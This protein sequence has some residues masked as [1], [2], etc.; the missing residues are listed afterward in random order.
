MLLALDIGNSQT[1]YGIFDQG[2]LL[3]HWRAET[4]IS[5]TPDEHAA[6]LFPLLQHAGLSLAKWEGIALCSVV[7]PVEDS[8]TLFC[9]EYLKKEP[10]K[11]NHQSVLNFRLNVETPSEVGADRLANVAYAVKHL[12]L[13]AIVVDLGTATTFDVIT[14]DRVYQG[15]VILPGI[16]MGAQSLSA[17]TSL[18][19][20]VEVKF[21][22]SAIGKNTATCIQSGVLYGYCE[23]IDGLLRR[24]QRE[25]EGKC[26]IVLTGGLAP[27][28]AS[29][30][31]VPA[32]QL[33]DLTLE[34]TLILYEQNLTVEV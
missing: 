2:K 24:L 20:L 33:P 16:R 26:E 5:R 28:I 7:P 10:F 8:F 25:I 3:K 12:T 19:P 18:L 15:G 27:M 6:F 21:P 34:G 1:S 9:R 22:P 4:Q 11:V 31:S 29:Q 32:K 23:A 13:P 17:K 30:L 14:A